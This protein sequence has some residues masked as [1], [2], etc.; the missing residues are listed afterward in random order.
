MRFE[1]LYYIVKQ[2][3]HT[4]KSR[5]CIGKSVL[6]CPKFVV[7]NKVLCKTYADFWSSKCGD[8]DCGFYHWC[9]YESEELSVGSV[10]ALDGIKVLPLF[11]FI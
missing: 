10:F 4:V 11:G 9:I 7:A 8:E 1:D 3:A 5:M 2:Y 6:L